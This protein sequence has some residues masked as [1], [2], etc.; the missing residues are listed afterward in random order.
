[1]AEII[2]G[3]TGASGIVLGHRTVDVLTALGH[4]VHLILSRAALLTAQEEMG[5]EFATADRFLHTFSE[6]KRALVSCHKI[7]CF[8][9]SIASGSYPVDGM[10]VI[11]CS[12]ATLAA[13]A[14]G[15]SDNLLRRAADVTLKERRRLVLVPRE[16]PFS[17]LHLENMLRLS[18]MGTVILPPVPAWYTKPQSLQDVEDFIVG[19]ALDALGI[20]AGLYPRWGEE[21]K[22]TPCVFYTQGI[23]ET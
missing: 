3:V 11:P 5:T 20:D 23:K 8:T 7:G 13:I 4:R 1:M 19:R 6:E 10:I 14:T 16:A 17:E 21:T 15:I 9:A 22:E 18:R 2:V 12:M